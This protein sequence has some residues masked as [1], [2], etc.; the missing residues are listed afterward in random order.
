MSLKTKKLGQGGNE[1]F[2]SEF[3]LEESLWNAMSETYK[4]RDA[5]RRKK[6]V[7]KH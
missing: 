2:I 7:S 3:E 4:S 5:K 1:M 6:Q